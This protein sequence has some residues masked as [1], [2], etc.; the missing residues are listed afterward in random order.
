MLTKL[1]LLQM[2]QKL[3]LKVFPYRTSFSLNKW[4][5]SCCAKIDSQSVRH[6]PPDFTQLN[7]LLMDEIRILLHTL[8]R[9]TLGVREWW[10]ASTPKCLSTLFSSL[11]KKLHVHVTLLL[12]GFCWPNLHSIYYTSLRIFSLYWT[13][14]YKQ[15]P[16][17]VFKMDF[18]KKIRWIKQKKKSL[19]LK[20]SYV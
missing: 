12:T 15:V 5:L 8:W 2:D 10:T 4:L 14:N 18:M 13:K 9:L 6:V 7:T 19:L 3:S 1:R 20:I 17:Y 16:I 11:L